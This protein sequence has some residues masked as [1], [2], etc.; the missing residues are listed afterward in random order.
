MRF[1]LLI[2]GGL[3]YDGSLDPPRKADLGI[4]HGRIAALG[5][6]EAE[7]DRVI[8]A[9]GL[10]VAPGFIDIHTHCD[11]TFLN[12]RIADPGDD[13]PEPVA[14]NLNYLTQGVTTVVSGNCGE[15]P[16]SPRR[17]FDLLERF[18]FG[19]NL[20]H[21]VPHG[22][23]RT[24][25]FG[26]DQPTGLNPARLE[27]LIGALEE[28]LDEGAAGLSTGLEY[29]PGFL[30]ETKELIRLARVV[31]DR[32]KIYTTHLRD[33]SGR[34]GP[35]GRPG[36]IAALEEAFLIARESG[37][38]VQISHL[39]LTEPLN[40]LDAEAVIDLIRAAR[41]EGLDITADQ[42][43]YDAAATILTVRLPR[44]MIG[45]EGEVKSE[46]RTKD[47]RQE[48]ARAIRETFNYLPPEKTLIAT[49]ARD[50]S[51]EGLNLTQIA[52]KLGCSPEAAYVT[53]ACD[54]SPPGAVFFGQRMEFV[55]VLGEQDFVMTGSDGWTINPGTAKP[56]PRSYGT[57]PKKL[58]MFRDEA[59]PERL[60]RA[61]R[62]MTSLPAQRLGLTD[63]GTLKV[64]QRADIAIL[65]M[66]RLSDES[67]YLDPHRLSRGVV[68]LILDGS[69]S[70]IDG[71]PNE[72][73]KGR[74]IRIN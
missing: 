21:L 35:D 44:E 32:G 45:A 55:R 12:S 68:S 3:V 65:D 29:A 56:H 16:A 64:G 70:L 39:K 50:T 7:A 24:E 66:D 30:A 1:D 49:H 40:G 33:E 61:I 4:R 60:S 11:L 53:L 37:A 58:R 74:A 38:A 67:T 6:V 22:S 71:Q 57:F 69:L 42:Y 34:I 9:R 62:S 25:V 27:R 51:L 52:E 46:F 31:A 15:G 14:A 72:V 20:L 41:D 48:V 13:P 10:V 59:R 28:A 43:P 73:R 47:G 54:G 36:L 2:S 26:S 19:T 18:R 5:K 17:W 63:R 8:D 23:L